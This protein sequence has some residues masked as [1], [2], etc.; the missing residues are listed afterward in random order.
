LTRL[1][2]TGVSGQ[3]YSSF[4][5]D[6]QAGVL[7]GSKYFYTNV[8]NQAFSSYETDLD[9][10]GAVS[11][12]ILDN[13][14]GSHRILGFQDNLTIHSVFNDVTT[15][16]GNNETFVF[17]AHFG[18]STVTDFASHMTGAGHDSFQMPVGDFANFS[19]LLA[20][21]QTVGGNAVITAANGDQLTLLGVTKATLAT[22][23]A[24]FSFTSS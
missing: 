5:Y 18:Q 2:F 12:Q 7:T 14:D 23:G 22:L 6:Y 10:N 9:A 24:D 19:S 4:E 3:S 11:L 17:T 8:P 20:G 15:G 13:N 21:T 16:G 1:A